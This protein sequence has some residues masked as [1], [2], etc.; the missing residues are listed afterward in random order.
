MKSVFRVP[1]G[2]RRR[3]AGNAMLELAIGGTVIMTAFI[4]SF[5]YGYTFYQY[6]SLYNAVN[7]GARYASMYPYDTS[8]A[9]YSDNFGNSVKSMVVNGDPTGSSTTAVLGGLT[10]DK[11]TITVAGTGN[12]A[13]TPSTFSPTSITVSISSYTV[14]GVFGSTT[15]TNKPS[16]TYPFVGN[17]QPPP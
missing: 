6:N 13:A 2:K 7:N 15:F 12:S 11:V 16:V 1:E 5:Q 9:T 8:S 4:Y 3:R 10:T 14:N 17:Y